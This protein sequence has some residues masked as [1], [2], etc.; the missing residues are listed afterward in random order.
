MAIGAPP[1]DKSHLAD[2]ATSHAVIQAFLE[3]TGGGV[4]GLVVSALYM[5]G[6]L[7][8]QRQAEFAY[9]WLF[10]FFFF[11]TLSNGGI[12]WTML[13]HISN[14]GW[15]VAVRRLEGDGVVQRSTSSTAVV[16]RPGSR[17]NAASSSGFSRSA[18][19]PAA[20][21]LRVVSLPAANSKLKK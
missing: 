18:A 14:S 19:R 10:A 12:F 7:G 20:M 8:A 17:R 1:A 11:F 2:G 6:I 15:S 5:F 9:S 13:Q 4:A 21:A 3:A 16:M